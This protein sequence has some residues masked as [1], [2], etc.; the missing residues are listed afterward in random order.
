MMRKNFLAIFRDRST[1]YFDLFEALARKT[2]EAVEN[3]CDRNLSPHEKAERI[4]HLE[5]EADKIVHAVANSLDM[6]HRPPLKGRR[7]IYLLVHNIDNILDYLEKAANRIALFRLSYTK[8][9][10]ELGDLLLRATREIERALPYFRTI[11]SSK[12]SGKQVKSAC[13]ILNDIE[14]QGDRL[15]RGKMLPAIE[16]QKRN[17]PTI[18][19]WHELDRMERVFDII[20]HAFDQ[21]EDVGNFMESLKKENV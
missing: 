21:C 18:L 1:N 5:S 20:E 10:F 12:Q 8:D 4:K 17:A 14:E 6:H 2:R 3:F 13:I 19:A 11:R 15:Y 7:E 9:I 16:Q